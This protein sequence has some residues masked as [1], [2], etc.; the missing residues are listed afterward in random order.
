MKERITRTGFVATLTQAV[1]LGVAVSAT[2]NS[3]GVLT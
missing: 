2:P 1:A 3:A